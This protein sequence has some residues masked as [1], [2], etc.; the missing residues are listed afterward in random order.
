MYNHKQPQQCGVTGPH[1]TSAV[2][3]Q[4]ILAEMSCG[5]NTKAIEK[6]YKINVCN[7]SSIALMTFKLTAYLLVNKAENINR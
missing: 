6:C 7:N 5:W 4:F 3:T 2:S 1:T